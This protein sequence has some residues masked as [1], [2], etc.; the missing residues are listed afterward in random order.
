[1]GGFIQGLADVAAII[2]T[3]ELLVLLVVP[4]ALIAFLGRKGMNWVLGPQGKFTWAVAKLHTIL[5]TVDTGVRRTEDLAVTPVIA[6]AGFWSGA[7]TTLR[8]LRRR[9]DQPLARLRRSS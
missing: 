2:L 8:S 5:G 7:R 4:A 1:M 3:L 9:A 6:V